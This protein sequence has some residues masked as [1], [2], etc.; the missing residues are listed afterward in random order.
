MKS[1]KESTLKRLMT[2]AGK[3]KYFTYASCILAAISAAI[4][5]IPFYDIWRII[6]EVLE[7]RPDFSKAVHIKSYGWQAVIFALTSMI[8][9]IGSLMCSHRAAFRV[10]ANMRVE[11]MSHIMKIPVGIIETEGTGKIRKDITESSAATETYLAHNLPDKVVSVVTPVCLI[12]MLAFFDWRLGLIS[13]IPAVI[14]FVLM[15]AFMMGPKMANDMK[16]YQNA[17][18]N[19]SGEA[20]EYIRGIPVVKTFGQ[21]L[22]SF[23]RFKQ[24]ID[25]YEKWTVA[26]TKNMRVPM[27]AFTTSANG[28]FAALIIAAYAFTGH[29]ITDKFIINLLFYII[30]T[31]VLTVTLMKVAYAGESK[32]LVDDALNRVDNIMNIKPLSE[33]ADEKTPKDASVEI[34]DASFSYDNNSSRKA[35]DGISLRIE[36]GS[37][38]AL[39]GPSGGGKTTLASL[40]ARFYDTGK[41]TVKIGG[42]DVK[43][44]SSRHLME[45]VSYVFQ[46]SHLLKMSILE[47]VRMGRPDATDYEVMEAL[48]KAQCMDIIAKFHDG[49]NTIIGSKG[50]FVSGGEAQRLSIARA[51]LKDAPVL[52]L[53]EATAFADPD[54]ECKVQHAFE[55]LAKNKTVIMIAHR[56]ST[57][58]SAD[59]IYVLEKGKIA[60]SGTYNEL[61]EKRGTFCHMWNEYNKSATWKVGKEGALS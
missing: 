46:D 45:Q 35:I 7:V 58:I 16:E 24:A 9:Y 18:G 60:E 3:Y 20:V 34:D 29:G 27:T 37:H 19:M 40:I 56:L 21:T 54:N 42:V 13:L 15:G 61:M 6:R 41:G 50:V 26:Y 47:N 55:N 1:K 36:E 48:E 11:M 12:G 52:I 31:S 5:L 38:I 2:Y 44:I 10:Q 33:T 22:Y 4:A 53:D 17:L 30:I 51:F 43:D 59:C 14:A 23:K 39:V 28:I 8:F 25:E 49:V 32:M 57:I